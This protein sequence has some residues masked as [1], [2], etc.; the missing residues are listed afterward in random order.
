MNCIINVMNID[1]QSKALVSR[2]MENAG[3]RQIGRRK[4]DHKIRVTY[5]D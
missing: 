5:A 4:R 1:A 3:F 2:H